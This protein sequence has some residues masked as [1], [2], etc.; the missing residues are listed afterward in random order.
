[1]KMR[2]EAVTGTRVGARRFDSAFSIATAT[3]S[4]SPP[5]RESGPS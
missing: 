5:K 3:E 1:M 2:A 4:A